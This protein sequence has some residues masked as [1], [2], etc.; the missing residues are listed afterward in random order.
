MR[1]IADPDVALYVGGQYSIRIF[2]RILRRT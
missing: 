1:L 2:L